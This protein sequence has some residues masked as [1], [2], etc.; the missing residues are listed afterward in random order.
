MDIPRWVS[1][2][3]DV[4]YIYIPS[5]Q[6]LHSRKQKGPRYTGRPRSI[7]SASQHG[8]SSNK[9]YSTAQGKSLDASCMHRSSHRC[10]FCSTQWRDLPSARGGFRITLSLSHGRC[11]VTFDQGICS[12]ELRRFCFG[13]LSE[14]GNCMAK[15]ASFEGCLCV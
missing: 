1:G 12:L 10:R 6:A 15:M 5:D 14:K 13:N 8:Q 2:G 4:A 11:S 9:S 3:V 7:S